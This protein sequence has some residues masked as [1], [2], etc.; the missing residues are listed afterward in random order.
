MIM[1]A[2]LVDMLSPDAC[3][4]SESIKTIE[5]LRATYPVWRCEAPEKLRESCVKLAEGKEKLLCS[6]VSVAASHM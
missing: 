5:E 4:T 3:S 6:R 2:H 1:I